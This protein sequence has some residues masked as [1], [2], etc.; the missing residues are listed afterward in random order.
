MNK[1]KII[2]N[3]KWAY[4]ELKA[5]LAGN[6]PDFVIANDAEGLENEVIV[7][8]FH[9]PDPSCFE[10]QMR[11]LAENGYRTID[12]EELHGLLSGETP[13]LPKTVMLTF[14]DCRAS[15]WSIVMPVLER[16]GLKA[17]SYLAPYF[18]EEQGD[19]RSQWSGE[20]DIKPYLE[21]D[22]ITG[23][24]FCTW[25][26]VARMHETG[27]IDFQAH[28]YFHETVFVSPEIV[29]FHN[30]RRSWNYHNLGLPVIREKGG[31]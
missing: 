11:F 4:P 9:T 23:E 18:I 24:L 2:A 1:E 3:L 29:D 15:L 10:R 12:T 8:S 31:R 6:Y 13:L 26:E 20:D 30:P 7:F 16:Y 14:D 19:L 28:T 5:L 27:V 22:F 21:R 17:V 25:A